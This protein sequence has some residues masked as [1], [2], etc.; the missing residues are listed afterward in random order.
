MKANL[1]VKESNFLKYYLKTGN[2][3]EAAKLAGS[4]GKDT[5]SLYNAGKAIIERCGITYQDIMEQVGITEEFLA[6]KLIEGASCDKVEIATFRGKIVDE[7]AFP[8]YSTRS[9]YLDMIHR[10]KGA[11]VDKVE[12][13]GRGGG[14]ISLVIVSPKSKKRSLN[15]D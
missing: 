5:F 4:K 2:I 9:K 10:V 13:S 14:D 15:I 6:E 11:Y 1:S 7:K 12:L 3:S 8:D